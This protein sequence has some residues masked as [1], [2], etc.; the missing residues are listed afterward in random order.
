MLHDDEKCCG[1]QGGRAYGQ[2][3][4]VK[5]CYGMIQAHERARQR[6]YTWLAR[7][8]ADIVFSIPLPSIQNLNNLIQ[9]KTAVRART[10]H[11]GGGSNVSGS[12]LLGGEHPSCT[13]PE[14]PRGR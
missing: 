10:A 4:K 13:C 1:T 7:T 12:I 9:A 6:K 8:R 3:S 11:S 14:A 5:A 2:F